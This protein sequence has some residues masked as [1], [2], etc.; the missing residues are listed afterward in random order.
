MTAARVPLRNRT[1]LSAAMVIVL[2]ILVLL[3]LTNCHRETEEEKIRN[4]ITS[5][6]KAVREKDRG[7]VLGH[8]SKTYRDQQ[9]NTYD[10]VKGLLLFF[11]M[12]HQRVNAYVPNL[13]ISVVDRSAQVSFQAVLTG[14]GGDN[15]ATG[16]GL[17][18]DALGV[19]TFAVVMQK[20]SGTWKVASAKWERVNE[21]QL[22]KE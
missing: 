17:L 22:P 1:H 19:Y 8:L 10:G 5:I 21:G 7:A 12:K 2:T 14:A 9:G 16:S 3:F 6:Q 18:P 4:V 11:F 15:A 13:D 20:E